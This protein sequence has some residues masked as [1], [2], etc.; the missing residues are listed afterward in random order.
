LK[1]GSFDVV[2]VAC[3]DEIVPYTIDERGLSIG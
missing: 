1:S 2:T 3:S